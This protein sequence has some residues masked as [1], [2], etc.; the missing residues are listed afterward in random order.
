MTVN[1]GHPFR[2]RET[3]S[4]VLLVLTCAFYVP[5]HTHANEMAA[6]QSSNTTVANVNDD[7]LYIYKKKPVNTTDFMFPLALDNVRRS[8]EMLSRSAL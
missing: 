6:E 4:R 1:E 3:L 2:G 5:M 8:K 7:E